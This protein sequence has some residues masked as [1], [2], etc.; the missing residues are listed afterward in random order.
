MLGAAMSSDGKDAMEPGFAAAEI[1]T[2]RPH[3]VR[4]YNACLGG[5]DNYLADRA[6]VRP[7]LHV[8]RRI[9]MKLF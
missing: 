2:S 3:P 1:D 5:N 8:A 4:M 6:A 9:Q 7:I